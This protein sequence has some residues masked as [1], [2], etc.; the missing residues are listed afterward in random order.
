MNNYVCP[1]Y[2]GNYIMPGSTDCGDVS[3]CA[4]FVWM[5]LATA[6]DGVPGH[7]WQNVS[8]SGHSIGLKGAVNAAKV[9]A[10]TVIDML[11]NPGLL[12]D[13]KAEFKQRTSCGY[14]CPIPEG[15]VAKA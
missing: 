15:L 1:L 2:D 11:E 5:N 3:W 6:P 4:P 13:A 9:M 7:S 12:A 10:G 14:S 8:A